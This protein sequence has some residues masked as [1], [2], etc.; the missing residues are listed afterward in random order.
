[1]S[2]WA[3]LTIGEA[4]R[5]KHGFA[6]P[7]A[8]FGVD[9]SM[10]QVLTP[11]NFALS[12]GFQPAKPKSYVGQYPSEFLLSSSEVV[13][14]MTDLSKSGDTLGFAA[15]LPNGEKF[16]HN[17]RI[18]LVEVLD[19]TKIDARFFQYLTRTAGYR[20]H[21]LGTAS[22]STVR[23]TSPR[24]ICD[25]RA[26]VPPVEEQ[27]A[28]AEVLGA[29]D[30]KIAANTALA[31]SADSMLATEFR[32][33]LHRAG[34]RDKALAAIANVVL[35]GTPS[36][37]RLDYWIN[38]T[39][40]WLNSGTV[41]ATRI[42]EP[43][44]LITPEALANSS[45]KLMP[46]GATLLAITGA[47]LGQIAR[48]EMTASGNQSIVGVWSDDVDLNTWLY[49]AIQWRLDDLL[50]RATGAAQQHVSKG[51]VEQLAV[52]VPSQSVLKEFGGVA[53]PVLK[54]AATAER[55]NQTLAATRD[56]L[57]PQLMSGQLRVRDAEAAA[58]EAGV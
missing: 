39:I 9:P 53:T 32:A 31:S 2:D 18:G 14:T 43:S 10:P 12:G 13:V 30:D 49:F 1:M 54:I 51:D 57:L 17:Q 29:L 33:R 25:Y 41:N 34:A 6:F 11:G 45:A 46:G 23:H 44:E 22:G 7:G 58:S 15:Q 37:A 26:V 52:P 24:R 27:Q 48:L 4:L 38:G 19:E 47:T 50:A 56:A 36:R 16:L 20:S 42:V 28:I 55:E 21:I 40:P 35:G 3:G 5:I 8:G